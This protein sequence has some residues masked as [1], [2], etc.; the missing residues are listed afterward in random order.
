MGASGTASMSH[1]IR[2][3]FDPRR[4]G[5]TSHWRD[6]SAP[7]QLPF[8]DGAAYRPGAYYRAG[9]IG[10]YQPGAGYGISGVYGG[11]P[12]SQNAAF[13][14]SMPP[15]AAYGRARA[16]VP[17]HALADVSAAS[18]TVA[19]P[20]SPPPAPAEREEDPPSP[21]RGGV[22]LLLAPL[23]VPPPPLEGAASASA[24]AS[25]SA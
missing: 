15:A 10:A 19:P 8:Y 5:A 23:P 3:G 7:G 21:R 9:E 6:G 14:P 24:S 2:P 22:R 25:A 17:M 18:R 13:H 4:S 1:A 20:P 12:A 11:I 16:P